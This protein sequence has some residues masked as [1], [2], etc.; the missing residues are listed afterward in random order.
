M[1]L[2]ADIEGVAC[3]LDDVIVSGATLTEHDQRVK[4]V[5]QRFDELGFKMNKNKCVFAA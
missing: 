2:L 1:S 3:L 5:L 4:L